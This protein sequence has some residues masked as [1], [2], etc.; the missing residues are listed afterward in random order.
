MLHVA[1]VAVVLEFNWLR[2][3]L[4]GLTF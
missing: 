4:I 1:C 2:V 3:F